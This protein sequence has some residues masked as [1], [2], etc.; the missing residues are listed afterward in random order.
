CR[1]G[2]MIV[3]AGKTSFGKTS[4]ALGIARHAALERKVPVAIF[5]TEMPA[6]DLVLR[7]LASVADVDGEHLRRN[8]FGPDE[9]ERVSAGRARIS[10][11]PLYFVDA[12][13]LTAPQFRIKARQLVRRYKVGLIVLD[14]LQQV[15]SGG[16]EETRQVEVAA[17]SRTVKLV[18]GELKVPVI[19]LS[20][21][22]RKADGVAEPRIDDLRASGTI[23]EDA[24]VVLLLHRNASTP[25]LAR[26]IVG[27]N[28]NGRTGHFGAVWNGSR[29]TF[30]NFTPRERQDAVQAA[31]PGEERE[32]VQRRLMPADDPSLPF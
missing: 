28:R 24:D 11:A 7:L 8:T 25:D 16:R 32:A 2:Q 31:P 13:G 6:E 19:A 21:L 22:S 30:R 23:E 4:L 27:K 10:E 14:Y 3:V 12:A 17:V 29:L 18:A 15:A 1:P 20:Q 9:Q 26:L 5:S